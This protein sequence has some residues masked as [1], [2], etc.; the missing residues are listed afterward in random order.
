MKKMKMYI[1][2]IIANHMNVWKKG[3]GSYSGGCSNF[4]LHYGASF[5][6]SFCGAL[7]TLGEFTGTDIFETYCDFFRIEWCSL[8]RINSAL[9]IIVPFV[10]FFI[11]L[12]SLL[13]YKDRYLRLSEKYDICD[14]IRDVFNFLKSFIPVVVL[15]ICLGVATLLRG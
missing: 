3:H 10:V 7:A 5:A 14:P 15:A 4:A 2:K 8:E 6:M 12:Y 9:A 13:R 11:A 1:E